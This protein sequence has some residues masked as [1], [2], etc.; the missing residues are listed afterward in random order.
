MKKGSR[1]NIPDFSS[2]KP[3]PKSIRAAEKGKPAPAPEPRS[4]I[5]PRATSAK[6]GRRGQ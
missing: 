5:K 4:T 3:D 2:R 6:S 1:R